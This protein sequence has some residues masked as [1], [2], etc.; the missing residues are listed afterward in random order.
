MLS[1]FFFCLCQ[2]LAFFQFLAWSTSGLGCV[3]AGLP[4]LPDPTNPNIDRPLFGGLVA[5]PGISL[6]VYGLRYMTPDEV[7]FVGVHL[8]L[9]MCM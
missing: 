7:K 1:F 4:G 2:G 5:C 8:Y 3:P 6:S 9:E